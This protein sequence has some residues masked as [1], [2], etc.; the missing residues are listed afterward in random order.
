MVVSGMFT[1][2][3]AVIFLGGIAVTVLFVIVLLKANKAL[4]IWLERNKSDL[5]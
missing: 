1:L 5:G 3:S 2:L 4:N